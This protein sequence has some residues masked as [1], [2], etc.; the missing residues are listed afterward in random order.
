MRAL[1]VALMLCGAGVHASA[2]TSNWSWFVGDG[3]SSE[4]VAQPDERLPQT[5]RA[6]PGKSFSDENVC[7]AEILKAQTKYGIPNNILLAIGLQE[8]GQRT[9]DGKLAPWP[10]SVNAAGVGK[11][12]KGRDTA[13]QWVR[14]KQAAGINSIDV[15]CMQINLR[16]HPE[17]FDSLEDGFNPVKNID[18]A[19]RLLLRLHKQTGDWKLAAGSYHSFTPARRNIYLK[20]LTK[21]ISYANE[22]ISSYRQMANNKNRIDLPA[23]NNVVSKDSSVSSSVRPKMA[24]QNNDGADTGSGSIFSDTTF[25]PLFGG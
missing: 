12:F 11:W 25:S 1:L 7:V 8:T 9:P 15:G 13:L 24:P 23:Q 3:S 10:W 2:S 20:S 16:W 5:P 14:A 18:Y 4:N 19:A 21:K 22:R 17:A 6:Q